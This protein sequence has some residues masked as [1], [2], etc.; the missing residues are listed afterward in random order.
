MTAHQ[1]AQP[2]NV[3][4]LTIR[5]DEHS[6]DPAHA[7]VTE[8]ACAVVEQCQRASASGGQARLAVLLV[9]PAAQSPRRLAIADA[10]VA[11]LRGLIYSLT[12]EAGEALILNL[13]V[14]SNGA[15][16]G[17]EATV[18]FLQSDA[19][20]WIRGATFDLRGKSCQS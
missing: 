8:P 7:W 17:A 15:E 16:R 19:A 4:L 14:V 9:L 20:S 2:A 10:A 13:L 12:L 3:D 18:K 11:A 1:P 6:A 5:L